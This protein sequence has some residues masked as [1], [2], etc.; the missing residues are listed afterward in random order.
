MK[1]INSLSKRVLAISCSKIVVEGWEDIVNFITWTYL[2]KS[3]FSL[4]NSL[5]HDP[6]AKNV[7]YCV[8]QVNKSS[9]Y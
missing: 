2:G 5:K 4:Q 8:R 1:T 7:N 9:E 3:I 6:A